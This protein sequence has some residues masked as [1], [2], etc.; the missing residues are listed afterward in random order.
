MERVKPNE[1][2]RRFHFACWCYMT[3]VKET[4][5]K[6]TSKFD[7]SSFQVFMERPRIEST[8]CWKN[9]KSELKQQTYKEQG[10]VWKK[11][12]NDSLNWWRAC[13]FLPRSLFVGYWVRKHAFKPKFKN[14]C[15]QSNC[16]SFKMHLLGS[17]RNG[18]TR[19]RSKSKSCGF[20]HFEKY[21][22][23]VVH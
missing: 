10:E 7:F 8:S 9:E 14:T 23:T 4:L 15:S 16:E 22:S 2:K 20:S 5:M 19:P 12:S 11:K 13:F 18:R 6:L 17:Y 21:H 3:C 1:G